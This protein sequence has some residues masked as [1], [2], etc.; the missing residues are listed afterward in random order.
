MKR[1]RV[2]RAVGGFF[3]VMLSS[4]EVYRCHIRGK[5]KNKENYVLVGDMVEFSLDA[6]GKGVIENILQRTSCFKRPAVANV[7]QLISVISAR[8]PL[9]DWNLS[10]RQLVSAES[11]NLQSVICLNKKDLIST[12]ELRDITATL[13]MFP[14][15]YVLTSALTGEGI[16]KLEEHLN[17]HVSVFTGASGVGKSSLINA[18]KPEFDLEI[19]EVSAKGKRGRHTTRRVEIL[20]LNGGMVVDTPGFTRMDLAGEDIEYMD[21]FFPEISGYRPLCQFRDCF[22]RDEPGC[23]VKEAVKAQKISPMRYRHYISFLEELRQG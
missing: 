14:Y 4:G 20:L 8:D 7:T 5:H 2:I 1:G 19:S 18:I 16:A 21:E 23:A 17:N 6:H 15:E 10:S 11:S 22:H 13:K 3:D 12:A 9:P